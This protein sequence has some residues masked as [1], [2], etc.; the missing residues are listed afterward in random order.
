MKPLGQ[1]MLQKAA[2]EFHGLQGHGLPFPGGCILVPEGHMIVI[3]GE[4]AVVGDGDPVD[5]AGQV[6]Q[7]LFR[8]LEGRSGEDDP[9]IVP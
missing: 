8:L 9:V 1:D 5:I 2:Q 3:H 4:N 6:S 7:H